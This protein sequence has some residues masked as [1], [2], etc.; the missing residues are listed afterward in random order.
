MK[1][2]VWDGAIIYSLGG[3]TTFGNETLHPF[4]SKMVRRLH[5]D[6]YFIPTSEM[7]SCTN[8]GTPQACAMNWARD[9][10][11]WTCDYVY[12]QIF[13]GTDLATSGY[14]KGAYPIVEVQTAKAAIRMATWFN[15]LVEGSYRERDV[16]FETVPS[17]VLGPMGGA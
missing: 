11:E 4:F 2:Q 14:S 1:I 10:N 3:V 7:I 6:N 15:K 16:F 13:N 9:T 5:S 17:W 12:S 8:P